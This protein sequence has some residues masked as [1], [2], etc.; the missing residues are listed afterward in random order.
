MLPIGGLEAPLTVQE[1]GID[2]S[3]REDMYKLVSSV[4]HSTKDSKLSQGLEAERLLEKLNKS[5]ERNGLALPVE[6]RNRLK[7]IQKELSLLDIEFSKRLNEENG[8]IWFTP[9]ELDGVPEDVVHGLQKGEGENAGKLRL[10]FKYPDLLPTQKY[11]TNPATRKKVY[12]ENENKCNDNVAV[13]KKAIKLRDERARLLGF[14]SHA[15]YV[16]DIKMAKNS[17]TVMGFLNNLREKLKA[18]GEKEKQRLKQLKQDDLKRLGLSDDGGF[19]LWDYR[20]V[21]TLWLLFSSNSVGTTTACSLKRSTRLTRRRLPS[22]SRCSTPSI[23][24]C[25]SS[26]SSLALSSWR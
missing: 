10:T 23:A 4:Y 11:A 22:T 25:R 20:C 19:F 6:K 1:F 26:R 14:K 16:L 9:E 21:C 7:E 17:E 24:C 13:F 18:G 15:E 12:V 8:G 5:Y 3:M 2:S